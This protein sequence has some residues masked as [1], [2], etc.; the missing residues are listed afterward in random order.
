ML[1]ADEQSTFSVDRG[2]PDTAPLARRAMTTEGHGTTTPFAA[3]DTATGRLI[4][5]YYGRH[6]AAKFPIPG[7]NLGR[8][9]ARTRHPS[10]HEQ[11]RHAQNPSDSAMAGERAA[12]VRAP[13]PT[14][15]R[16]HRALRLHRVVSPAKNIPSGS[17]R[18]GHSAGARVQRLRFQQMTTDRTRNNPAKMQ[19][20]RSDPKDK[21]AKS[22]DLLVTRCS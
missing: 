11:L 16:V 21:A 2:P 19:R 10:R 13:T 9:A 14:D 1:C 6:R 5:K 22:T 7:R 12:L 3:L 4:G 20:M 8:R 17:R 18:P 15:Q